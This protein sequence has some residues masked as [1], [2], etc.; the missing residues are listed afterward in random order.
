M[1]F[2]RLVLAGAL[3]AGLGCSGET[4]PEPVDISGT[5]RFT[6]SAASVSGVMCSST[7]TV[8]ISQD[9][10]RFSGTQ[11]GPGTLSCIGADPAVSRR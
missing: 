11:Q 10:E 8:F 3:V 5:W 4:V 9:G 2:S 7:M 1:K 6:F